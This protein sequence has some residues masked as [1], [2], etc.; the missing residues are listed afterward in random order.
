MHT[1]TGAH[2]GQNSWGETL[3]TVG[4]KVLET[5]AIAAGKECYAGK[6]LCMC[7]PSS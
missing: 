6:D 5:V 3:V 4:G 7:H 2:G 1:D